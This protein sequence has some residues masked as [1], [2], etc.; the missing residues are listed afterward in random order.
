[1][2]TDTNLNAIVAYLKKQHVLTLCVGNGQTLWC[3]NCFYALDEATMCLYML[4]DG[5]TRHGG[6]L[7]ENHSVA[8]TINDQTV[9]VSRIKG[10]QYRGDVRRL[11]GDEAQSARKLYTAR[12]PLAKIAGTPIWRLRL[13]EIKFTNNTLGFGTKISWLRHPP[14]AD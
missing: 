6:L 12:F 13:D 11:E 14:Q 9:T 3:A 10:I 5:N 1:M 2:N 4:T 8:G 7:A